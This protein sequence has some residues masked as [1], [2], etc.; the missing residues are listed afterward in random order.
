MLQAS[1]TGE[2]RRTK[3]EARGGANNYCPWMTP[4]IIK[5][6]YKRDCFK[7]HSI[8]NNCLDSLAEYK[9]TRNLVTSLIRK[10]KRDYFYQVSTKYNNCAKQLWKEI[11]KVTGNNKYVKSI[12]PDL[13][14][15][16][17]NNYFTNVGKDIS[18]LQNPLN[19]NNPSEYRI[20]LT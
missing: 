16:D 8:Q 14:C 10:S 17:M 7:A 19:L 13:N 4:C 2:R 20:S 5:L 18:P 1:G 9:K 15:D 12:H 11:H 3:T 6:M